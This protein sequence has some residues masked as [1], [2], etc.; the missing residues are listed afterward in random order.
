MTFIAKAFLILLISS[1]ALAQN[2]STEDQN[3][4]YGACVPSC[5]KGPGMEKERAFISEA[6]CRCYCSRTAVNITTKQLNAINKN[7]AS[8]PSVIGLINSA[9]TICLEAVK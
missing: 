5:K 4:W 6:Y 7:G 8:D 1:A 9:I 2:I 3:E